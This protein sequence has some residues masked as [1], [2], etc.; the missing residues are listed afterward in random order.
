M[1][2]TAVMG[3]HVKCDWTNS[4]GSF[5]SDIV[6]ISMLSA[7]IRPAASSRTW[8]K[9]NGPSTNDLRRPLETIG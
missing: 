3:D 4:D 2:V 6:P 5:K 8:S 1:T 9:S 7:P